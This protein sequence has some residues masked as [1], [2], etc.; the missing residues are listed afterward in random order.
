MTKA[1]IGQKMGRTKK[2]IE[3]RA[4]ALKLAP[5]DASMSYFYWS[6]EQRATKAERMKLTYKAN[7]EVINNKKE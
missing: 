7:R 4:A 1:Q 5:L 2:A 6:A 3:L